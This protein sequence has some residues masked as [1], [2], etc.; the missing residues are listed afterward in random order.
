V[1]PAA[2]KIWQLSPIWKQFTNIVSV[3]KILK[4]EMI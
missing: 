2:P 1:R 3:A 4:A